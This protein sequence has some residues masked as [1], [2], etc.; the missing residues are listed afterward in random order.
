M[1]SPELKDIVQMLRDRAKAGAE[2]P[3]TL[4]ERRAGTIAGGQAFE[5]LTGV[6]TESVNANSVSCEWVATADADPSRTIIYLHGGGYV[7]GSIVSHRGL[8][9]S[10]ARSSKAR[11]LSVDYRLAPEHK[12]PAPVE[13]V[14]SVYRWLLASGQDASKIALVGDS[15]GGGLAIAAMVAIKGAGLPMPGAGVCIS[16]WVDMEA[17]SDSYDSRAALD[18]MLTRAGI[19]AFAKD[20]LGDADPKSPMASPI[21]ADLS[22]LPPILIQVGTSE[23]IYDDSTWLRDHATKA[24]VDVTFEAWDDMVHVWHRY[25]PKLPE[26][27]RAVDRLGEFVQEKLG[28]TAVPTGD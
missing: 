14:M 12:F 7:V 13:D 19:L 22:G 10:V 8:A 25:A 26:A 1:A 11:V 15:A 9:A 17:L 18:P 3:P 6:G 21:Y 20:Y 24:G 16:P 28:A 27:Q 23:A 5:D 4:D 2:N